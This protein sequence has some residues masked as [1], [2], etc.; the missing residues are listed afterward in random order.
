MSDDQP[1]C[2]VDP[3]SRNVWIQKSKQLQHSQQKQ[4]DD[5]L[6]LQSNLQTNPTSWSWKNLIWSSAQN[7]NMEKPSPVV[8]P[9]PHDAKAKIPIDHPHIA[10]MIVKNEPEAIECSS[11][12]MDQTL[13][14]PKSATAGSSELSQDRVVSS[15]PRTNIDANWIYPSEK[16]FFNAM[17]R[18][19]WNPEEKDM[20]TVVPLHNL[21]NEVTWR[22]ILNWEKDVKDNNLKDIKLTS[23]KGDAS[24]L[25]P[26]AFI[27]HYIFGRDLPFDRHD[28]IVNRNGS[29]IE[30]VIDFYTTKPVTEGDE[31]KFYL[32][33]RPKLNSFEGCRMRLYRALG[34]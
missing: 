13:S 7:P 24:R 6:N 3:K 8:C 25:T 5:E 20:K 28:W 32:D 34:L 9:I 15:I 21:V 26:R 22:Y 17:L 33:V 14:T 19:N 1:K 29:E 2:P 27:G 31:P 12:E 16:Q 23:F 30:Y 10:G 11:A 4:I 18:K